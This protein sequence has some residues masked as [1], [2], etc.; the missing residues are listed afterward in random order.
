MQVNASTATV[1]RSP[2]PS[3]L[4]SA[5]DNNAFVLWQVGK[6]LTALARHNCTRRIVYMYRNDGLVT[7]ETGFSSSLVVLSGNSLQKGRLLA[8]TRVFRRFSRRTKQLGVAFAYALSAIAATMLPP[9]KTDCHWR[10]AAVC[11]PALPS[12]GAMPQLFLSLRKEVAVRRTNVSRLFACGPHTG[13][14]Q[15]LAEGSF[16]D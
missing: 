7:R 5:R 12:V 6:I 16:S 1:T 9:P 13:V 10:A 8:G 2:V 3:L 4:S 11:V 14:L 15:L